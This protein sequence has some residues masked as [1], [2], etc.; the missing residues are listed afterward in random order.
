MGFSRDLQSTIPRDYYLNGCF[1]DLQGIGREGLFFFGRSKS[2]LQK[3]HP[4]N[5][6]GR[7]VDPPKMMQIALT[8]SFASLLTT[9]APTGSCV[10]STS[11]KRCLAFLAKKNRVSISKKHHQMPENTGNP[12]GI[13]A[14]SWRKCSRKTIP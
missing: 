12:H 2:T 4:K 1:L 6:Q 5:H 9:T 14:P 8:G 3:V 7:P 13:S 11:T 10:Y